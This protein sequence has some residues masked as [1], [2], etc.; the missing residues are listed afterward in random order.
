M[1]PV[2]AREQDGPQA[3]PGPARW[4]PQSFHVMVKPRGPICN[5]DCEYCYYLSKETLFPGSGFRMTEEVLENYVRSYIEAQHGPEVTFAWQGGEPTLMGLEFFETVIRLQRKHHRSDV[6]IVNTLQ[7]NGT[8]LDDDWGRFFKEHGFLIGLSL[9]GP[10]DLHDRYRVTK[11]G[12]PSFDDVM[13][14]LRLLQRHGVE[15]NILCCVH[16]GNAGAPLEVY[17]FLRDEA[18]ALHLQFIPIVIRDNDTGFQEGSGVVPPSVGSR[19]YGEFLVAIFDDWVRQDV[20][21]VFVQIFDE[22]LAAWAGSGPSLCVF[23]E[24][25]GLGLAMEHS[26][27]LYCCDHF[28]EPRHELGNINGTELADLVASEKQWRF[29]MAKRDT[30]TRYC[31]E[32]DV[33]FICNGGCPKNRFETTPDGEP[34]LDYLCEGHHAFFRHIDGLMQIMADLW[35]SRRSPA[36]IMEIQTREDVE[37][38]SRLAEI[39]R[40]ARCPCGSGKKFK[41]CHGRE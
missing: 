4:S 13:H 38:P 24:T 3:G 27:D 19:Q 41:H 11:G 23:Q 7:T 8:K 25:C 28:V 2:K 6:R 17:R 40:N 34:G 35:R 5:L 21:R 12:G 22:A 29:G 18:G 1:S 33:R 20:G 16:E 26:G 36:L 32:C 37:L 31:R 9:D 30:L 14:G 15:H 39:S 10:R